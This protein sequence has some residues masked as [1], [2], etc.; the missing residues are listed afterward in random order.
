MLITTSDDIDSRIY[1]NNAYYYGG[2]GRG[3]VSKHSI[4]KKKKNRNPPLSNLKQEK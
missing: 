3:K 2:R 4:S 1:R